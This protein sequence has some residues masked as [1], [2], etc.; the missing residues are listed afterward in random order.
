VAVFYVGEQ[1]LERYGFAD[2]ADRLSN[3]PDAGFTPLARAGTLRAY[4]SCG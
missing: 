4:A 3:V 1:P 2:G